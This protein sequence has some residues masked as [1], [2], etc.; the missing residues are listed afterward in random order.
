MPLDQSVY[1]SQRS[2]RRLPVRL[3]YS[4]VVGDGGRE[5]TIRAESVNVSKSGMRVRTG[6]QLAPGQTVEVVLME[7]TPRPVVAKVV[8]AG[9]PDGPSGYEF[10]LEY[11]LR[12]SQPA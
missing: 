4:L 7:G 1:E 3:P 11:V 8:W 6:L 9:Q 5:M 10:G 12:P 2:G